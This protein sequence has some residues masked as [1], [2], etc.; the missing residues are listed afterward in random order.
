MARQNRHPNPAQIAQESGWWSRTDGA[1]RRLSRL[2]IR[3]TPSLWAT[4]GFDLFLLTEEGAGARLYGLTSRSIRE[5]QV[6]LDMGEVPACAELVAPLQATRHGVFAVAADRIVYFSAHGPGAGFRPNVRKEWQSGAWRIAGAVAAPDGMLWI[7]AARGG[8]GALFSGNGQSEAWRLRRTLARWEFSDEE[9]AILTVSQR[10]NGPLELGFAA[11]GT[12]GTYNT[13][14]EAVKVL[15]AP[16]LKSQPAKLDAKVRMGLPAVAGPSPLEGSLYVP[17]YLDGAAMSGVAL[18]GLN[19]SIPSFS[20]LVSEHG[21]MASGFTSNGGY[22]AVV[23]DAVYMTGASPHEKRRFFAGAKHYDAGGAA[24]ICA[25]GAGSWTAVASRVGTNKANLDFLVA[26]GQ[27]DVSLQ[28]SRELAG[29]NVSRSTI[30]PTLPPV[31]TDDTFYLIAMRDEE[32][33]LLFA[34]MVDGT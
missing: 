14:S 17:V 25:G 16:G 7:A 1:S 24:A 12:M 28:M 4:D 9:G 5:G 27:R 32:P 26:G 33:E 31:A 29:P 15:P 8:V 3:G 10:L 20:A 11:G 22:V 19:G 6:A 21:A 2:G 30:V 34:D 23:S 13:D 18:F